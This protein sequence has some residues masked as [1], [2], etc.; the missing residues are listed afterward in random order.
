MIIRPLLMKCRFFP[1]HQSI[2]HRKYAQIKDYTTAD[3]EEGVE[4]IE[5]I[6]HKHAAQCRYH[7]G[8]ICNRLLSSHKQQVIKFK[9]H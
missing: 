5:A 2:R 3:P 6:N 1:F 4:M 7:F 9:E 8:E